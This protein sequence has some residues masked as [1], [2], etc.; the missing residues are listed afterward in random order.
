MSRVG[1]FCLVSLLLFFLK[2]L[3]TLNNDAS[4]MN[5]PD[6]LSFSTINCNS[7]NMSQCTSLIQKL[8]IYGICKLRTDFIFLSDIRMVC[9]NKTSMVSTVK[10][11]FKMNP[12][13]SYNFFYNSKKNSRGV[14]I[15][16]KNSLDFTASEVRSDD[17]DNWLLIKG[18]M[19]GKCFILG[20]VYGPNDHDRNFFVSLSE[21]IRLM[22][23]FPTILGGDWNCTVSRGDRNN[24]IDILNMAAPPNKRHSE[25]LWSLCNDCD[26]IEPFRFFNPN[27]KEFTFT[28][29]DI[30]KKN[31]SRIDFFLVSDY[32]VN[33]IGKIEI[34]QTLQSNL[35]D[36]KAV[37]LDFNKQQNG[38]SRPCISNSI[39]DD[40]NLDKIVWTAL[41]ETYC[42]HATL[43]LDRRNVF[44]GE[45]GRLK[46]QIR[47]L[48]PPLKNLADETLAGVDIAGR[49][50]MV[51]DIEAT[52]MRLDALDFQGW[53]LDVE[54]DVFLDV[55]LNSIRNEVISYQ[56]FIDKQLKATRVARL[57]KLEEL[58]LDYS[59]NIVKITE[60]EKLL[61][62]DVTIEMKKKIL[63][64]PAFDILNSE[65]ITPLFAKM[66]KV[67][68][69][70]FQ[71]SDVKN[72]LDTDFNSEKEREDFIVEFYTTL[73][74]KP[75]PPPLGYGN[76]VERFLGPE[77]CINP[78]VTG[79]KLNNDEAALFERDFTLEE[80]DK[81]LEGANK[82]SAAGVDGINNKFLSKYWKWIREPLKNYSDCCMRKGQLTDPFR[83]AIIK[84]IPKKGDCSKIGNWRPISLLSCT[85]KILSRALNNRLKKVTDKILSRAQKGFTNSRYIQEVLINVY[86][87]IAYCK[88]NNIQGALVSIDQAKAF[89]SV[90]PDYM[91]EVYKFFGFG[92]RF[93]NMVDTLCNN[94]E[95]CIIMG[96]NKLSKN[97][98]LE[99]GFAQGNPPSPILYNIGEQILL[100]K[101]ELDPGIR[102]IFNY[103]QI[104][105]PLQAV[106]GLADVPVPNTGILAEANRKTDKSEAFADDTNIFTFFEFESLL[107]LKNTL[108][109][110]GII[111]GLKCN[112][113]KTNV[114][115][116]GLI[117]NTPEN[118]ADLG[119]RVVSELK[120]LGFSVTSSF[121]DSSRNFDTVLEKVLSA[122][123][124]WEK[125][126][127]SLPGR[128]NICKTF[129]LSQIGYIASI[130]VPD[131]EQ[132]SKLQ[133][134]MDGFC[135]G[136]INIAKDRYYRPPHEAGLGLIKI[137]DF[138]TGL[139]AKWVKIALL[140]PWDNWRYDLAHMSGSDFYKVACSVPDRVKHP[141]Y[142]NLMSSFAKFFVFFHML[143][144]NFTKMPIYE[145]PLIK[146]S[147]DDPRFIDANLLGI[148][149]N[150]QVVSKI[151]KATFVDF[152]INGR[153]RSLHEMNLKLETDLSLITYIRIGQA[154]TFFNSKIKAN[155][156]TNGLAT[157][158]L[159]FVKKS[160][161]GSKKFRKIVTEGGLKDKK[162]EELPAVVSFYN[163]VQMV[164]PDVKLINQL[165]CMWSCN[166]FSIRIREF[167][168]K[169]FNNSLGLNTRISN[170]VENIDRSCSL[171]IAGSVSPP[172][173]ESFRHLFFYCSVTSAIQNAFLQRYFIG[174]SERLVNEDDKKKLWFEFRD[175]DDLS[176]NLLLS[177][178]IC[179]FQSTIWEFKLKRKAPSFTS[180]MNEFTVKL[181]ATI[182]SSGV[183][184]ILKNE[185]INNYYIFRD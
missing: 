129:M 161:K 6:N 34:S 5:L 103:N 58:K 96:E 20:V 72:D 121:E 57:L 183:L 60:I 13:K 61:N 133:K 77:I 16:I 134:T 159:F 14:G 119:F 29:R 89:D 149:N 56:T 127:L 47:L 132:L 160:E 172:C 130:L 136:K 55:L 185:N 21:N 105:R 140:D 48:G 126:N 94:R 50:L 79:S 87:N 42:I 83:S 115:K 177:T 51:R 151:R 168:F 180:F 174:L 4:N 123:K 39:L 45:V 179:I 68:N 1:R 76:C 116:I 154:L 176:Y 59:G 106:R 128:I 113:S 75:V 12:Y 31:R 162:V 71:L 137:S 108:T 104:P 170:F 82:K 117:N 142:F 98:K 141:I 146:R 46:N 100:F 109:N 182:A 23:K 43:E 92:E 74:R 112:Y 18:N 36:H 120:I 139:Q 93:V 67:N 143:N 101:I 73:Y 24:N 99:S 41:F 28:P 122:A 33:K 19:S 40:E 156:K 110:F 102:S 165:H 95:A 62:L 80:L 81:A 157:S 166:F 152:C 15:L 70:S 3:L 155:R 25:Y 52:I 135:L 64:H 114:L 35:F 178:T 107:N 184:T 63:N 27:R 86:E 84:L 22:G 88:E 158:L 26:L 131:S 32:L 91:R 49:Q 150:P 66:L 148:D 171:C 54:C 90:A 144:D 111:S 44:L 7:L 10:D 163:L 124:F 65:K 11:I 118:I 2:S 38:I 181:D 37:I 8:K 125:F 173:E 69:D 9:K 145:N 78:I 164:R 53:D 17:N 169:F 175:K 85:Y 153:M 147:R 167:A 30:L 97:F 138:I